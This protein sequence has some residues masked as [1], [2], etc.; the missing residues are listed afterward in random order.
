MAN[1][2][3]RYAAGIDLGGTFVK[4]ALVSEE[5]KISFQDK[6]EIGP[7][8]TRDDILKILSLA[9]RK[10]IAHANL[11]GVKLTGIGI[12]SPG[13]IYDG[14]VIGG[15]DNLNGWANVPLG[16]IFSKEFDL[17]VFADN[18]ANVMGLGEVEFGAAKGCTD[19]IFLTVG[20]GIG[21][22]IVMN[23][24]LYGGYKNRG[25][26]MGHVTIDHKGIACNC[27]GRGCLEAYASTNALIG[28]YSKQTGKS[29][30]EINGYYIVE[31]FLEGETAA[32]ECMQE[33]TDYL[34]HAIA[35]F[36]NT[37]APQK[38]IIG[39]GISEAGQFYIDMIKA[40]TF[41]Y[42]MP[43]CAV[44]TDVIAATLGNNAGCMGAAS[45]VFRNS[46]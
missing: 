24:Q 37:F 21:G 1:T 29:G 19:A 40:S 28:Q 14:V 31:K 18:D 41:N 44:H 16:A 45:L 42:A 12:G 46:N 32:V 3:M 25:T 9:I 6:I 5:G 39:G 26:E 10:I 27:G 43:D 8:A 2:N 15:A 35:G 17:P 30:S 36:V 13:I 4:L 33:H 23:G 38:V 20:T 11:E 22:A 34:G 7:K